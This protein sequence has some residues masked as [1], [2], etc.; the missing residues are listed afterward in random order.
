MSAREIGIDWWRTDS[1]YSSLAKPE[2]PARLEALEQ[3][4]AQLEQGK[5]LEAS[6]V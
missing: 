4:L 6:H 2:D 1:H 3:R 5:V